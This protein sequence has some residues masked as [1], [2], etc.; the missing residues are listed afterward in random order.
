MESNQDLKTRRRRQATHESLRTDRLPPYSTE[1]EQGAI[2]CILL[3]PNECLHQAAAKLTPESFYD[4]RHQTIYGAVLEMSEAREQI[5]MITLQQHLKDKRLLDEIGGIS[6]LIEL[7]DSAPSAANL[8][9][10]ADILTEKAIL[11]KLIHTAIEIVARSYEHTGDIGTLLDAVERDIMAISRSKQ[12]ESATPTVKQ[13]VQEAIGEIEFA[14]ENKGKITGISTGLIDLDRFTDGLHGGESVILAAFPSVGKTSLAMNIA[15][16]VVLNE[17]MPV[18]V[19]SMEMSGRQ[20]TKRLL[21]SH[22]R[23]NIRNIGE[24]YLSENDFPKLT[25][26]AGKISNAKLYFDDTA[27]LSIY[28]LRARAR[29]MWQEHS[30]KFLVIDYLQLMNAIGGARKIENRV[31]E[32]ADISNGIKSLAKELDIP[33][34]T[35]SQ[36]TEMQGGKT[37]LRGAAEIGQDADGVWELEAHESEDPEVCIPTSLHI[38]KQRNGPRNVTVHLNF[39]AA[40]TRFECAAKVSQ[41]DLPNQ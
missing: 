3:S 16:H 6:Y 28:Q 17:Q 9:Y 38:R 29:R 23:V 31:Q 11:R 21:C 19:F 12:T 2:G 25:N 41:D 27:G 10:Y 14:F 8:S 7:Q 20:L 4:L 35:L 22:A 33:I 40:I 5:D 36:L 37:R 18:G 24:G 26:S 34:L 13:L 39:I 1:A 15:E 30:I 32:L